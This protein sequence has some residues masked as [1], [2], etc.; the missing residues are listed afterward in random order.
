MAVSTIRLCKRFHLLQ[1]VDA[2][3]AGHR[4]TRARAQTRQK[5]QLSRQPRMAGK[6]RFA[7]PSIV[8]SRRCRKH[9]LQRRQT[10]HLH[11]GVAKR[12]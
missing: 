5:S 2:A 1:R 6:T 9:R 3:M 8:P 10:N 12:I 4:R 7:L 11:Q